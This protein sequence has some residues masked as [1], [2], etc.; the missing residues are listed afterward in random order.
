MRHTAL[1]GAQMR[2]PIV[3]IHTSKASA[4]MRSR[5][6][7]YLAGLLRKYL[8]EDTPSMHVA[9]SSWRAAQVL[10]GN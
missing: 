5:Y 10:T 6:K 7:S 1:C 3:H 2:L 9:L 4:S 8:V